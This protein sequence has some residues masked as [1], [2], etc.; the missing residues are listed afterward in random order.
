M[1]RPSASVVCDLGQYSGNSASLSVAPT[2]S[3]SACAS[4]KTLRSETRT[5]LAGVPEGAEQ[6]ALDRDLG[7]DH[8]ACLGLPL[9]HIAGHD[10]GTIREDD[11]PGIRVVAAGVEL[12]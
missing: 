5:P 11:Q 1:K 8:Q 4:P 6:A 3:A 10:P 9:P 2:N 7:A 12:G